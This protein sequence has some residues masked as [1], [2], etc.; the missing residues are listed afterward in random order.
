MS[1]NIKSSVKCSYYFWD[2]LRMSCFYLQRVFLC[3]SQSKLPYWFWYWII[4]HT[5]CYPSFKIS[6]YGRIMRSCS[7]DVRVSQVTYFGQWHIDRS[8]IYHF[9]APALRSFKNHWVVLPYSF[10]FPLYRKVIK[11]QDIVYSVDILHEQEI[12]LHCCEALGLG[13]FL[14][15]AQLNLNWLIHY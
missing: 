15:A 8:G 5:V 2:S 6:L 3:S 12:N 11:A 10:F 7:S 4:F 9:Q 13:V 14:T 1:P